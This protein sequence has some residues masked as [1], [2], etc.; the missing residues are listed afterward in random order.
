MLLTFCT[1][2]ERTWAWGEGGRAP[3]PCMKHLSIEMQF[4]SGNLGEE[5]LLGLANLITRGTYFAPNGGSTLNEP[6]HH[7][8]FQKI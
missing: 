5:V 3:P 8:I 7:R 1:K 6:S 2:G 4:V